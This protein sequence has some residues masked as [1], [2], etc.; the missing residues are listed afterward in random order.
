MEDFFFVVSIFGGITCCVFFWKHIQA[1]VAALN[2]LSERGIRI[3]KYKPG[4]F[5]YGSAGCMRKI[6]SIR[7]SYSDKLN[8]NEI[9]LLDKSEK[10]YKAQ[11]FVVV[12]FVLILLG[13]LAIGVAG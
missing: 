4:F 7:Y 10:L 13:N 8:D 9:E 2:S 6:K 1:Y 11:G 5:N 12:P 3:E